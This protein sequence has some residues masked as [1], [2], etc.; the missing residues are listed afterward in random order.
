MN[1][2]KG[3]RR[4][5]YL[6]CLSIAKINICNLSKLYGISAILNKVWFVLFWTP[7]LTLYIIVNSANWY[8]AYAKSK[9]TT[10]QNRL[11][12]PSVKSFMTDNGIRA[13][14]IEDELPQLTII[15]SAGYGK[16]YENSKNAGISDL[17]AKT[18]SLAGS[19]NFQ[20]DLLHEKVESIGGRLSISS[21]WEEI[22]IS[23]RVLERYSDIA[24]DI[25]KDLIENPNFDADIITDAKSHLLE[26]IRRKKDSPEALAF[27]KAKEIVFNGNGY[28][29]VVK[30]D[31]VSSITRYQ[32]IDLWNKYFNAGNIV[33]GISSSIN[34][35]KIKNYIKTSL[36]STK[37][38][39]RI[40]YSS[41]SISIGKS[42]VKNSGNIYLIPKDLP[43]ATI[44]LG[45]VAPK[46][47]DKR[48]YPL[49]IMNYILG[50]GS[51]NSRLVREIRVKRGLA[52]SVQS[53]IRFRYN[54]GIFLAFAQTRN[55]KAGETLELMLNNLQLM[56]EKQITQKELKWAK[57]SIINSYI[58]KFDTL[59]S[60]LSRF[61]SLSYYGFSS[62]YLLGYQ[63]KIDKVSADEILK[64]NKDLLRYGLIK[65]IVGK[66][67]LKKMLKKYGDVKIVNP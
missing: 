42:I 30:E 17:I 50:G 34:F 40:L 35:T 24:F 5:F 19:K 6:N 1:N 23:I 67:D 64:S 26:E 12:L 55:E 28:G 60:I 2:G 51:F 43:Q 18:L 44:V 66:K 38:G 39:D 11:N 3:Y 14:Y 36:G 25:V 15:V 20:G 46:I 32:M 47:K 49:E 53:V 65:V 8:H 10:S 22:V 31:T 48:V 58:F 7:V 52:Y 13:F 63:M 59:S 33:I 29:A 37:K 61:L 41:D 16:L 54:T 57:E 45:T 56:G 21:S 4:L 27:D 62:E 9:S